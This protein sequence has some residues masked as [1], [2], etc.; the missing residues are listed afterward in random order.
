MWG[1]DININFEN[2]VSFYQEEVMKRFLRAAG[3]MLCLVTALLCG[4]AVSAD[5]HPTVYRGIDYAK[6]YDYDYFT[7]QYPGLAKKYN[8]DDARILQYFVNVG[9]HKGRRGSSAFSVKSYRYGNAD[10]RRKYG[11]DLRKYYLHYIRY[12]SKSAK[13]RATRKGVTVMQDPLTVFEGVDYDEIY[14]YRYFIKKYPAVLTSV[15]D[16]DAAVLEYFV[17]TGMKKKMTAKNTLKYPDANPSSAR[18]QEL[19]KKTLYP[20]GSTLPK[21]YVTSTPKSWNEILLR[22][23]SETQNGGGYYTGSV[24]AEHPKTTGQALSEAYTISGSKAAVDLSKANPSYC[25]SAVY[26]VMMKTLL[27]WDKK[28]VIPKKAWVNLRPYA[29]NGMAYPAQDDGVGCWGRANANGPGAAVLV[30]ELE[31]GKNYY[32]GAPKE[33][34]TSAGYEKAWMRAEPGDLL[35]IFR[36]KYIGT[37]ES[38]HMVVYLGHRY[39][40]DENGKRDDIIY[41]WS[42]QKS[43]G[44]Y[45]ITS[46]PRSEIFRAVLTKITDPAAFKNAASITP[47]DTDAWLKS[48]VY[49]HNS[50]TKE[51]I[52]KIK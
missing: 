14:S 5:G 39:A 36:T 48:L 19:F 10:L 30:K 6:V 20:S 27:N 21:N 26:M 8:Y 15:G 29:I 49:G 18:Y 35:K 22:V 23:I 37:K 9:M 50:S 41:Y 12:G 43:T 4:C 34:T 1:R 17:R 44:G 11:M 7:R 38:G 24:D 52:A 45:G 33:Y 25:S 16:D 42:S 51:M 28:G 13:R 31:A 32:I 46:C 40:L 47:T 3:F 2:F